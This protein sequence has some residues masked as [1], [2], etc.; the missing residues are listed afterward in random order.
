MCICRKS[1]NAI[2]FDCPVDESDF[3]HPSNIPENINSVLECPF[4]PSA[5]RFHRHRTVQR[6]L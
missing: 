5:F 3:I 4:V 6:Q 1:L 2:D